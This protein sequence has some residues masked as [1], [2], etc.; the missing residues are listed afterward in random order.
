MSRH[1]AP[2]GDVH[3]AAWRVGGP[4]D[5]FAARLAAAPPAD[6]EALAEL[7]E[8]DGRIR[9]A[10]GWPCELE[11]YLA[12]VPDLSSRPVALDAAI[13]MALRSLARTSRVD[14]AAVRFMAS[15]YPSL[16]TAIREA[17]ALNEAVW[18]TTRLGG[19]VGEMRAR[20]LP[21]G[22][23]PALADGQRRYELRTLLGEG[24]FGQV[25]LAVDRQ[26]SEPDHPALVSVKIILGHD[27]SPWARH[28]L[29]DEATK[30][31]RIDHPNVVRVFDRGVSEDDEDYIVYEFVEGGDLS[32][33]ARRPS[34]RSGARDLARMVSRAARGVH[35]AH[36]A[37]LVHCDLKPANI[38]VTADGEPKV[39][40]FGIATRPN[41]PA[42]EAPDAAEP[43]GNLAFMSPEQYNVRPGALTIPTDVYALGG[44]L[45]WLLT[46]RLPNGATVAE[47]R[48]THDPVSGR[49]APPSMREGRPD[50]DAD[51]DAVCRR[52][53]AVRPEDRH[54]SA[55]ALADDLDAWVSHEPILWQRPSVWKRAR[56]WMR[57]R[58]GQAT[59]LIAAGLMLTASAAVIAWLRIET[60]AARTGLRE[61]ELRREQFNA[62]LNTFRDSYKAARASGLTDQVLPQIFILEWMFGPTVLG[63][64][65]DRLVLWVDRLDVIR[66]RLAAMRASDSEG[67]WEYAMWEMALSFWLLEQRKYPEAAPLVEANALRWERLLAVS[68]PM[69]D[70]VKSLQACDAIGLRL[71]AVRRDPAAAEDPGLADAAIPTDA[72]LRAAVDQLVNA[73]LALAADAPDSP[74]H[75]L[76]RRHLNEAFGPA[77]LD[78]PARAA[79]YARRPQRT[80]PD[81]GSQPRRP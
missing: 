38:M 71:M 18:S 1:G 41:D 45:Y 63:E 73:E 48:V 52:A 57:R 72:A 23:G 33:W 9:L 10:H 8:A 22:F 11:R 26:L 59:A 31:R 62:R 77:L 60:V 47:I 6:D 68:D 42:A 3:P 30:A 12:A 27:R 32:K 19:H 34:R 36:M 67:T 17:A 24:A 80:Q 56:L 25:Y 58:P 15:R 13:D 14:E 44:I 29:T 61:E 65:P 7:I 50:L 35:A 76:V 40:D 78:D 53:M 21:C 39:A 55:A 64:G 46:R 75:R 16:E 43:M 74:L 4:D 66:N 79:A 49:A 2:S 5:E 70:H 51:L 28:R 81:A 54:S 69:L 37:G 20:T